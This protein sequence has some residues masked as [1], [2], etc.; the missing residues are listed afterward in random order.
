MLKKIL[1]L[2]VIMNL[3]ITSC[4]KDQEQNLDINVSGKVNTSVENNLSI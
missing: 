4:Q 2:I 1:M 3:G